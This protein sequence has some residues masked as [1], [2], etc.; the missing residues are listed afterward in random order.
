MSQCDKIIEYLKVHDGITPDDA[1]H[2]FKCHRLA[3]RI[4]ELRETGHI[5]DTIN[6][7]NNGYF[8]THARYLLKKEWKGNSNG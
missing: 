2:E 6:E 4:H 1:L 5:I 3:A 7:P 8:G